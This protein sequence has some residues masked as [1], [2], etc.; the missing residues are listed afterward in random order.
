MLTKLKQLE[1]ET[2]AQIQKLNTE[3][4]LVSYRNAVTGKNGSL[5]E[6]LK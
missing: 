2:L 5:T 1:S 4:E 3:D 6:I